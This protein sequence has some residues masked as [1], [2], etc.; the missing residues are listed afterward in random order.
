[1]KFI[2]LTQ[3]GAKSP[4]ILINLDLVWYVEETSGDEKIQTY[5]H[6]QQNGTRSEC[7]KIGV[8]E[9]YEEIKDMMTTKWHC[10]LY[11]KRDL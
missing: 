5:I 2:E 11:L 8:K 9:T 4:K 7:V 10:D 6:F 3:T 1:M